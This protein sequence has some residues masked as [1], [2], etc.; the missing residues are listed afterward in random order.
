MI[1]SEPQMKRIVDATK[2]AEVA[3]LQARPLVPPNTPNATRRKVKL[4]STTKPGS[5]YTDAKWFISYDLGLTWTQE[6]DPSAYVIDANGSTLSTGVYY[7][8]ELLGYDNTTGTAIFQTGFFPNPAIVIT[9]QEADGSPSYT[10]VS[11]LRFDQADGFTITNPSAGVG[12][13]DISASFSVG[14][15]GS[16]FNVGGSWPNITY[17]LPDAGASSRGAITT[18]NQTI[19][20]GKTFT[21]LITGTAGATISIGGAV[22]LIFTNS[23]Q[24]AQG[25]AI[26]TQS[27]TITT[28]IQGYGLTFEAFDIHDAN[29]SF[30]IF[31]MA[32]SL[33]W[34]TDSAFY[35]DAPAFIIGFRDRSGGYITP[36]IALQYAAGDY[37]V[38]VTG[39]SGGGDTVYGGIITALGGGGNATTVTVA[40]TTDSTC[41][42]ALFESQTGNL[43]PK[44][45]GGLT[46]DASAALLTADGGFISKKT[47]A[48]TSIPSNSIAGPFLTD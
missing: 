8:A 2:E 22:P 35:A 4:T 21:S 44:S 39:T 12:R 6:T 27:T 1:F 28:M 10:D 46:Y 38:G 33:E 9:V 20:G 14:T 31:G 34:L 30:Q 3:R 16:D 24:G 32:S 13:V 7:D 41:W 11:T 26:L 40:D 17:N 5:Y 19:A 18:G 37:R 48:I 42:V 36:R 29:S 23:S 45:D 15:S 43:A 47:S 25:E